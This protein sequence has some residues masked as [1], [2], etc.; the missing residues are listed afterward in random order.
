M[1][2]GAE[3]PEPAAGPKKIQE[4]ADE[5]FVE[6][7]R[8]ADGG[9]HTI[10]DARPIP[11]TAVETGQISV[12][13]APPASEGGNDVLAVLR[14]ALVAKG[15]D[16]GTVQMQVEPGI[17]TYPGGSYNNDQVRVTFGDGNS[18]RYSLNLMTQ[19]PHVTAM[20]IMAKLGIG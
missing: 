9:I 2:T 4:K 16:P 1:T 13:A 10:L 3:W 14:Q 8:G 17:C 12:I 15:C 11:A 18:E 5:P 6:F 19:T 7:L 20:E